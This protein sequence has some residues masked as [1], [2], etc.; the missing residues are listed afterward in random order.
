M[1]LWRDPRAGVAGKRLAEG[2]GTLGV[3]HVRQLDRPSHDSGRSNQAGARLVLAHGRALQ[4]AQASQVEEAKLAE[5]DDTRGRVL[6][7]A[8][9]FFGEQPHGVQV[10]LADFLIEQ[11]LTRPGS[12]ATHHHQ[13]VARIMLS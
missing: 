8:L 2:A 10:E 5:V 7:G 12:L 3:E 6:A 13:R 9:E 4:H 11:N 1:R